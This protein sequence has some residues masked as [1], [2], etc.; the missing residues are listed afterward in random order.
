MKGMEEVK[1][2]KYSYLKVA[3][4]QEGISR[5]DETQRLKF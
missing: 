2:K 5:F 3:V 1:G 4:F